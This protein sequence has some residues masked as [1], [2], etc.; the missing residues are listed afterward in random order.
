M[1]LKKEALYAFV[2]VAFVWTSLLGDWLPIPV[3]SVLFVTVLLLGVVMIVMGWSGWI[4]SRHTEDVPRWR[5]GVGL[6]GVTANTALAIPLGSLLYR[7]HY[8]FLRVAVMGLSMTDVDRIVLTA[9][10]LSLSALIAGIFAP[11]RCRFAIVLGGL[12]IGL[13]VLFIPVGFV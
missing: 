4:K 3:Q 9:S 5:K 6:V 10:V 8:P 1:R 11:P 2:L 13:V 12:I 7:M